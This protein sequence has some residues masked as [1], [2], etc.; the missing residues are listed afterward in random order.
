MTFDG[1]AFDTL[2][3]WLVTLRAQLGIQITRLVVDKTE[4]AGE[5]NASLTLATGS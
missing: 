1:V 3:T 2:V 5:V 4:I